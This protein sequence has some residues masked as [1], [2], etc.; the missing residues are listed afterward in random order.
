MKQIHPKDLPPHYEPGF[1][2]VCLCRWSCHIRAALLKRKMPHRGAMSVFLP[3][4]V[5]EFICM[6]IFLKILILEAKAYFLYSLM[7]EIP[8]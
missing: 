5:K 2:I 8:W 4:L 3:L 6:R 1:R 7:L